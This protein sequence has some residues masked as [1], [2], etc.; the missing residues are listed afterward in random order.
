MTEPARGEGDG[1]RRSAMDAALPRVDHAA[2]HLVRAAVTAPS[3]HNTQP[4]LFSH[5]EDGLDLYADG[6]RRLPLCDADGREQLIS[7]GAAL[8][9]VRL[10]MRRLG[11]RP[12][13]RLLPD[14]CDPARLAR[15]GWGAYAR[16]AADV[17]LMY[18]ALWQRHTHRGAFRPS[19]LPPPLT[20]ELRE[21][22]RAE[23]A[24]LYTV[25][26]PHALR[27]LGE[28]VR[29]A[30]AAHRHDPG[31]RAELAHWSRPG[32]DGRPDG[33]PVGSCAGRP[34]GTG[35]TG[36]D[37][38]GL[39]RAVPAEPVRRSPGAGLV[40][41]LTTPGDTPEDWLRAG[42][43]LQRVLLHA[44]VRWTAAAF[45]TQPLEVPWLR[46]QVRTA[47]TRGE[48]PQMILRLGHCA[49]DRATPRRPVEAVL[50]AG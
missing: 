43:A 38:T 6:G 30:E 1:E 46:E 29:T 49:R 31:Y 25:R 22:A 41:V 21:H 12:V 18:R 7:C 14:P 50:T 36:R 40:V 3:V 19:P 37:F 26:A 42:L 47:I 10:A 13:V 2:G 27:H 8:L 23:G 17:N 16:P 11:H 32:R 9:N 33:V 24:E 28:L 34:D 5:G 20:A 4:W 35:L 48:F 15:V 44:T 45:H 39:C